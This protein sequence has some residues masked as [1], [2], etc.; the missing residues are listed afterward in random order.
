MESV[1]DSDH[2]EDAVDRLLA[3]DRPS[4]RRPPPPS[5]G[6]SD[7]APDA[8]AAPAEARIETDAAF[9]RIVL[10]VPRFG[11]PDAG[12]L[13]ETLLA[14]GAARASRPEDAPRSDVPA[15]PGWSA[16]A[17][18]TGGTTAAFVEVLHWD[19]LAR[20][21]VPTAIRSG[22]RTLLRTV[23][24]YGRS[25]A[26]RRLARLNRAAAS[27]A[28]AGAAALVAGA[29]LAIGL[30]VLGGR[31]IATGLG[32]PADLIGLPMTPVHFLA[33]FA[34]TCAAALVLRLLRSE[35]GRLR[36]YERL[37]PTAYLASANGAYP[38]ELERRVS[39]FAGRIGWA[40][41]QPV[42]EVVVV[43]HGEGAAL[44]VSAL[45][46]AVR[47]GELPPGAPELSLLTLGQTIPLVGF[48]P[49]AAR[50]RADLRDVSLRA[51]LCWVD[52]SD[53]SDARAFALSD[54]VAVCGVAL[55]ERAGP[56]VLAAGRTDASQPVRW[57][58]AA[59]FRRHDRYLRAPKG[60]ARDYDWQRVILGPLTL[61]KF[62]SGRPPARGRIDLR[63]TAYASTAR[64][65]PEP[66]D[67]D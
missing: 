37:R 36:A 10:I 53:P 56:L 26:F 63:A 21:A 13:R 25:G 48:L 20:A 54:P 50:L 5:A 43:G 62:L 47:W 28:F 49:D 34:G 30:G 59:P 45:A 24:V 11:G 65:R 18:P 6:P 14:D 12:T 19:D 52:V 61:R 39:A 3:P 2:I 51:D 23:W 32:G 31:T 35:D 40:L 55:D 64:P 4:F 44:A 16:S 29:S 17:G 7:D 58:T 66:D 33:G 41:R 8:P 42:D 1:L 22:Y 67:D 57:I 38:P 9:S 27:W 15:G 46:E 60:S